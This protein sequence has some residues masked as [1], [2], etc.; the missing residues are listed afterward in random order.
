MEVSEVERIVR[1]Y[2]PHRCGY[3]IP[4]LV[5]ALESYVRDKENENFKVGRE[6]GHVQVG[7]DDTEEEWGR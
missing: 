6:M 3:C 1:E 2:V 7:E 4:G 5:S